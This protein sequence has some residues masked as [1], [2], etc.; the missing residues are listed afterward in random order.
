MG[1]KDQIRESLKLSL[2]GNFSSEKPS[3]VKA[4]L[5][6]ENNSFGSIQN[7]LKRIIGLEFELVLRLPHHSGLLLMEIIGGLF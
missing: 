7:L 2:Q 1:S 5:N 3:T 6:S 4:A